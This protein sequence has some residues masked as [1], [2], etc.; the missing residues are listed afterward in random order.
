MGRR[1]PP[2][3]TA[4]APPQRCSCLAILAAN[5]VPVTAPTTDI[6]QAE[7]RNLTMHNYIYFRAF[8][9]GARPG[10]GRTPE[11]S[12][13]PRHATRGRAARGGARPAP[14]EPATDRDERPRGSGAGRGP[15][16]AG[17]GPRP[18]GAPRRRGLSPGPA[19]PPRTLAGAGAA[20]ARR[21]PRRRGYVAAPVVRRGVTAL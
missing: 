17:P 19:P 5:A 8:G 12:S 20:A 21:A 3:I 7:L 16:R 10:A 18:R 13:A 9:P 11:I 1:T 15:A 2:D 14:A 6:S 4:A